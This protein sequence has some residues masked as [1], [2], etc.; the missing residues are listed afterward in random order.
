[1]KVEFR[2]AMDKFEER[3]VSLVKFDSGSSKS[4]YR[5]KKF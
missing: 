3:V 1:M 2:L 5:F 4:L